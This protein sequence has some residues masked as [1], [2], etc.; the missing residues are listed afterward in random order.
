MPEDVNRPYLSLLQKQWETLVPFRSQIVDRATDSL[1]SRTTIGAKEL[2]DTLLAIVLLDNLALPDALDLFLHQRTRSLRDILQLSHVSQYPRAR[3]ESIAS[4]RSISK[5]REEISGMLKES[6]TS[7]LD[8][9][10]LVRAVFD[11]GSK[12]ES[13]LGSMERLIQISENVSTH[14]S[15]TSTPQKSSHER[16]AS[17][18]A[19]ISTPLPTRTQSA[20]SPP[21]SAYQVLQGLPSAQILLRYLPGNI[22]GFTPFIAPSSNPDVLG[23]LATW[24]TSSIGLLREAIPSWLGAL[25]SVSD[26][27]AV[28]TDLTRLL[29][30]GS[31]EGEIK[32]ALEDEWGARIQAV[33]GDKLASILSLAESKV[34]EAA[35]VVNDENDVSPES[36]IF[37]ELAFP[38]APAH[39]L[40]ASSTPFTQFVADLTKRTTWRTPLLH[41]VL[42]ALETAAADLKADMAGL[43]KALYESYAAKAEE[44]LA[45]LVEVL[46]GVMKDVVAAR[47]GESKNI[48][49][50]QMLVGRVAI[51]LAK[52]SEFLRDLTGE[53]GVQLGMS[54]PQYARSELMPDDTIT[55]LTEV[56]AESVLQWHADSVTGALVELAPLF[57]PLLGPKE[58]QLSWQG[59][60][61]SL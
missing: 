1:R 57:D 4:I 54:R 61:I 34:S 32:T 19:S 30:D 44:S 49:V 5:E 53:A 39:A 47:E 55:A 25:H 37:T 27:W 43:P 3:R 18:L 22:T 14:E 29:G 24:Q 26:V 9:V 31:V 7:F 42:V 6:V 56:H 28:R 41:G 23:K 36:Y 60:S 33:W 40:T 50:G 8:T 38:P 46:K 20:T 45:K 16:R 51:Y 11:K 17:R 35:K 58:V 59:P 48:A 15:A 52:Q 12:S 2:A 10:S 21:I 13:M